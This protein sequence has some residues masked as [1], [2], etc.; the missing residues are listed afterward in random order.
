MAKPFQ[1]M[2]YWAAWPAIGPI[3]ERGSDPATYRRHP[4]ATG[5]YRFADYTPGKSLTLVRNE[6]WDPDTDPG[7]H[8]Y[9][10]RYEFTFDVPV[11]RIDAT[12]LGDSAKAATTL[13]MSSV[14]ADD[15]RRVAELNQLAFGSSPCTFFLSPDYRKIT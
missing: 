12:I 15:Y 4:L 6:Y 13:S 5:P 8:A 9:P 10:D 14:S 11:E 2:P 3:P 1:D 7:R